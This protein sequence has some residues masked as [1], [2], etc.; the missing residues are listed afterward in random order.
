MT[1]TDEQSLA[2]EPSAASAADPAEP[3]RPA[4]SI[5]ALR[6]HGAHRLDPV[7]FR[8]IVALAR[9]SAIHRGEA[10]RLL[11]ERLDGLLAA[12]GPL[13]GPEHGL[14]PG[15]PRSAPARAPIR[16]SGSTPLTP[17]GALLDHLSR[18]AGDPRANPGAEGGAG[19]AANRPPG[20]AHT[21]LRAMS[22]HRTTWTRLK[23]DRQMAQAQAKVP[24]NAG[25]L[26]T[27]RLLHQALTTMRGLSPDYVLRLMSHVEALLV[28]GPSGP[29]ASP[30]ARKPAA[31]SPRER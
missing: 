30:P 27:Q 23:V 8:R 29:T 18:Q 4:L 14:P 1:P 21:E 3:L 26:H 6:A 24:Q 2:G 17:L 31:R 5:E 13:A 12:Y 25:P 9:R 7:R 16:G 15:P 22:Q 20:P 28:L 10:R 11:D 19:A